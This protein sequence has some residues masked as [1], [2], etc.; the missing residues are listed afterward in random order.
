ML[1]FSNS[2]D[3]ANLINYIYI[4]ICFSSVQKHF[5]CAVQHSVTLIRLLNCWMNCIQ[6]QCE[7]WFLVF[8]SPVRN[9]PNIFGFYKADWTLSHSYTSRLLSNQRSE[10]LF[11]FSDQHSRCPWVKRLRRGD[12]WT[13]FKKPP[14]SSSSSLY[15]TLH[16]DWTEPIQNKWRHLPSNW[17][18]ET[19]ERFSWRSGPVRPAATEKNV[20][21]MSLWK[22]SWDSLFFPI[23]TYIRVKWLIEQEKNLIKICTSG[24]FSAWPFLHTLLHVSKRNTTQAQYVNPGTFLLHWYRHVLM[25]FYYIDIGTYWCVFI[26]L[27]QIRIATVQNSNR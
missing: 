15:V 23:V 24:Y 7:I 18:Q 9:S 21:L 19:V 1:Q 25:C 2:L 8:M 6:M 12:G 27:L 5:G 22:G 11:S 10:M 17:F 26:T 3:V 20:M 13:F 14:S 4:K 16:W